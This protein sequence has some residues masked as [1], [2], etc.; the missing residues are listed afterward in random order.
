MRGR[1]WLWCATLVSAGAAVA[2]SDS[3]GPTGPP[4]NALLRT[5]PVGASFGRYI[6]ISGAWVCVEGCDENSG[7]DQRQQGVPG[8]F[9]TPET[10]ADSSAN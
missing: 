6:L 2:C 1:R 3:T 4:A 8:P 5:A 9:H 10:V 7:P